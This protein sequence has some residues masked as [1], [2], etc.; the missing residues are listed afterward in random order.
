MKFEK[1]IIISP[2]D[3]H[4]VENVYETVLI[5]TMH[6]VSIKPASAIIN[7]KNVVIFLIS[8]TNDKKHRALEIPESI[9]SQFSPEEIAL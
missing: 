6:I 7:N 2:K 1:F 5:N 3:G 8:T 4:R 9:L